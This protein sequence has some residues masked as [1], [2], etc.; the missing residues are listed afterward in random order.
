MPSTDLRTL[1]ERIENGDID[2]S[3]AVTHTAPP[4][5]FG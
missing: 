3:F 1:L 5:C 4:I 2:P